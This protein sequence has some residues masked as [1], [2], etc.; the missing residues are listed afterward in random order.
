MGTMVDPRFDAV[1][2]VAGI[3]VADEEVASEETGSLG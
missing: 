3:R 2:V 1:V